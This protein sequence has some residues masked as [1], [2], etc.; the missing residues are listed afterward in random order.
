MRLPVRY[1]RGGEA[2]AMVRA[3]LNW[4]LGKAAY[5][6]NG[7]GVTRLK[8][9]LDAE[10]KY[11]TGQTGRPVLAEALRNISDSV[12]ALN[13]GQEPVEALTILRTLI[14]AT[15]GVSARVSIAVPFPGFLDAQGF[16]FW[17]SAGT[18]S[19]NKASLP[20]QSLAGL[21][22]RAGDSVRTR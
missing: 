7:V 13:P 15:V 5:V 10:Q 2:V 17:G 6:L 21:P 19:I 22:S 11:K 20:K 4:F 1:D 18:P 9:L 8:E 3:V 12:Q 14:L 16:N